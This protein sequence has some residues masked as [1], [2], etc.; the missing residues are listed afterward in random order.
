MAKLAN[1]VIS[2]YSSQILG[3]QAY[4]ENNNRNRTKC[5]NTK[6]LK[7]SYKTKVKSRM[8]AKIK[9]RKELEDKR[10]KNF[11][12]LLPIKMLLILPL[13]IAFSMLVA[14]LLVAP[15]ILT[16]LSILLWML[17]SAII[18]GVTTVRTNKLLKKLDEEIS[19]DREECI[20]IEER[21]ARIQVTIDKIDAANKYTEEKIAILRDAIKHIEELTTPE[22]AQ[23]VI[24]VEPAKG[25]QNT[26]NNQQL[27]KAI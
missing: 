4:I 7:D 6:N 25:I 22:G 13:S 8:S 9:K 3:F 1:E 26:N 2:N 5:E 24:H 19:E 17:S 11:A 18:D 16:G 15:Y 10:E 14:H 20:D 27:A 21:I 12:R 23:K